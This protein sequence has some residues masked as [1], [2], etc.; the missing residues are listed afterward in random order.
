MSARNSKNIASS[1]IEKDLQNPVISIILPM[2]DHR[3]K[4]IPAVQSWVENQRCNPDDF[5]VILIVD[6]ISK[7][8]EE[9]IRRMLRTQ[10]KLISQSGFNYVKQYHVGSK[11]AIGKWLFFTEPHCVAEP[12]AIYEMIQ[13]INT[14]SFDGFCTRTVPIC[15][16]RIAKMASRIFEENFIYWSRVNH[17]SKV[18]FRGFA[19]RRSIYIEVGG[20][21]YEYIRFAESLFAA[22][23]RNEGYTLGYAPGVGIR[24]FYEN[25][26][27]LLDSS[28]RDYVAGECFYRLANSPELFERFFGA[29]PEWGEVR[30]FNRFLLKVIFHA[31]FQQVVTFQGFTATFLG[32]LECL[33][34]IFKAL[35]LAVFG[36]RIFLLKF[37]ILTCLE[38]LRFYLWRHHEDKMYRAFTRYYAA[39]VSFYRVKCALRYS[40]GNFGNNEPFRLSYNI[41]DIDNKEIY[42]FYALESHKEKRFRWSS[43]VSAVKLYLKS[44]DY[45]VTL[46]LNN[47]RQPIAEKEL[48]IFLNYTSVQSVVYNPLKCTLTFFLPKNALSQS[49]QQWLLILCIP[50]TVND[51]HHIDE[52][53]LGIPLVSVSFEPQLKA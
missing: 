44:D 45:S 18:Y 1:Q 27:K 15:S 11:H 21:Q 17:W 13:Y 8:F 43:S 4:A 3:G 39:K 29:P 33:K 38:K 12:E 37:K 22:T 20:F 40:G 42:G 26:F 7:E 10:D 53:A 30:T 41:E 51:V 35:P 19:I 48:S 52:R 34:Q 36:K 16:N 9:P 23:L 2:Q 46:Q 14:S 24:H 47:V 50:W 28:L 6:D 32:W 31:L 5:E 49:G 25:N